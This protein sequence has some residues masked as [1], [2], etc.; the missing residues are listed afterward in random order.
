MEAVVG[1]APEAAA[2]A[3]SRSPV[4]P[5]PVEEQ[6][7]FPRRSAAEEVDFQAVLGPEVAVEAEEAD[8]HPEA[9]G[10]GGKTPTCMAGG[11]RPLTPPG[12][13]WQATFTGLSGAW[14]QIADRGWETTIQVNEREEDMPTCTPWR[15][16]WI[17]RRMPPTRPVCG[18]T[19]TASPPSSV[20]YLAAIQRS[21]RCLA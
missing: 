2:E 10:S 9:Q 11:V 8:H 16:S 14:R 5:G 7:A 20:G 19:A 13:G 1:V 15:S 21:M 6:E 4:Y 3:V 12:P 17:L 18:S